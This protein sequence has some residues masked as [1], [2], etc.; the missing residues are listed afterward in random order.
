M[1]WCLNLGNAREKS[2][3]HVAKF[4]MENL[5]EPRMYNPDTLYNLSIDTLIQ[6]FHKQNMT[7]V[8]IWTTSNIKWDIAKLLAVNEKRSA[9]QRFLAQEH[10]FEALFS[11]Q[12]GT[13]Q[14][15]L[16]VITKANINMYGVCVSVTLFPIYYDYIYKKLQYL[17]NKNIIDIDEFQSYLKIPIN[18]AMFL[19]DMGLCLQA[20]E[21]LEHINKMINM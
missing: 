3:F 7:N 16:F 9:L 19:N 17:T 4:K 1:A 11:S 18:Y 15:M 6:T 13:K 12:L 14:E 5:L 21:V 10:S 2:R 8:A 20:M